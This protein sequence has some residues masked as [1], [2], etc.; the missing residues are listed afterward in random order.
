[1]FNNNYL[2]D[3]TN[4]FFMHLY[5]LSYYFSCILLCINLTQ[6]AIITSIKYT[7]MWP[8]VVPINHLLRTQTTKLNQLSDLT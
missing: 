6:T 8:M 5:L 4:K 2:H 7:A 1:M 3:I